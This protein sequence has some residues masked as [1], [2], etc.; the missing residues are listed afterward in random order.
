MS[1]F[2]TSEAQALY[3]GAYQDAA[4]SPAFV[5]P[6]PWDKLTPNSTAWWINRGRWDGYYVQPPLDPALNGFYE[7]I[8]KAVREGRRAAPPPPPGRPPGPTA[9]SVAPASPPSAQPPSGTYQ[10][11]PPPRGNTTP[12]TPDPN[13]PRLT[14]V[15]Y[16]DPNGNPYPPWTGTPP[17]PYAPPPPWAGYPPSPY[18]PAP[19]W[20]QGSGFSFWGPWG[21]FTINQPQSTGT[22]PSPYPRPYPYPYPPRY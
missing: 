22:G 12:A 19:P 16:Q 7:T 5:K 15:P 17:S 6:D 1:T 13:Q 3:G 21:N 18:P 2:P 8:K 20:Q 14:V 9:P 4:A 11:A 10:P